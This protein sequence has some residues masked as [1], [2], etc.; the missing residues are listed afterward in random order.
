MSA[1]L[2]HVYFIQGAG[3]PLL[4]PRHRHKLFYIACHPLLLIVGSF[5]NGL[6]HPALPR[7]FSRGASSML[8]SPEV[9]LL[10]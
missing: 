9:W 10:V 5:L 1:L 8:M 7:Q 3:Q 6:S 4:A 2:T